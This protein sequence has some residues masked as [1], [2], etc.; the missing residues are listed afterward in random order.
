MENNLLTEDIKT[1]KALFIEP[2]YLIK[3]E[4]MSSELNIMQASS[5]DS[6]SFESIHISGLN[7]KNI[8]FV[9]FTDN[10]SLSELENSLHSRTIS[11]L[12]LNENEI[13]FVLINTKY[14][15]NFDFISHHVSNQKIVCYGNS[16]AYNADLLQIKNNNN[17]SFLLCPSLEELSSNN[18]IKLKWWSSLKNFLSL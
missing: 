11:A 2:L 13:G 10:S 12:K 3:E 1:L 17:N 14:L 7:S 9:V 4:I 18:E 16:N 6:E 5:S 15:T 8:V